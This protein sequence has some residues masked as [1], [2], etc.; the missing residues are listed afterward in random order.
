MQTNFEIKG[1]VIVYYVP[2]TRLHRGGKGTHFHT[3]L[4]CPKQ[5]DQDKSFPPTNNNSTS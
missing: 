3:F 5:L 4:P 2:S 1:V